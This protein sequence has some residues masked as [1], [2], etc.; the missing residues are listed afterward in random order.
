MNEREIFIEAAQLSDPLEQSAVLRRAC[1]HDDAL[2]Q[3]LV[4]LLA[5]HSRA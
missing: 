4:D 5:A 1:G 2:H 3:R